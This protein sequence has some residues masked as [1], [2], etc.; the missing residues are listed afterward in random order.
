MKSCHEKWKK[1]YDK[2]QEIETN[3]SVQNLE[4]DLKTSKLKFDE[5]GE[6]DYVY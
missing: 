3:E 2:W 4:L 5:Q 1:C 6:N